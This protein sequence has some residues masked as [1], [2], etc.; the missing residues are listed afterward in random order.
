MA[1]TEDVAKAEDI[2]DRIFQILIKSVRYVLEKEFSD[3]IVTEGE[4]SVGPRGRYEVLPGYFLDW[5]DFGYKWSKYYEWIVD[6]RKHYKDFEGPI[7]DDD[8]D[9]VDEQLQSAY[10]DRLDAVLNM[11]RGQIIQKYKIK[12]PSVISLVEK[13][14]D[15]RELAVLAEVYPKEDNYNI[16]IT[17]ELHAQLPD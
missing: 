3:E 15:T 16:T 10:W 12:D 1:S 7:T 9:L 8:V 4:H 13:I 17:V 2:T 11:A 14:L 6:W 5:P